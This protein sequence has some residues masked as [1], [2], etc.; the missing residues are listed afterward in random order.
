MKLI[1]IS[2]I[3]RNTGQIEGLPSNP[4]Q[5]SKEKMDKLISNIKQYPEMLSLRGLLVYPHNGKYVIIGG[6][7]RYAALQTLGIKDVPCIVVPNDTPVEKLKAYTIL[8]NNEFGQWDWD[9][10][11]NEWDEAELMDWGLDIEQYCDEQEDT[12]VKEVQVEHKDLPEVKFGEVWQLGCHRLKCGDSLNEKDIEDLM[13]GEVADLLLTDPPYNVNVSNSDGKVIANDNLSDEEFRLFLNK[14]M[15]NASGALKKG[16]AFYVWYGDSES[17]NFRNCCNQN[18]LIVKQCIIWVKS[19]ASLSRQDYNWQHEPCLYGW[20]EGAKHFFVNDY[21][22]TT[23]WEDRPNINQM[24]KEEL[25]NLIKELL[26]SREASTVI[27][28]DKPAHN[29]EHPTMKPIKLMAR[30]IRNSSKKGEIVLDL[31]GGSGSTLIACEQLNRTCYTMEYS[32]EYA[33]VIIKRWETLSGK[34]ATKIK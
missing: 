2:Q 34:K 7:M 9:M 6:N 19:Q 26:E 14:A 31:F 1:D 8:D 18:G 33:S 29:K 21:T 23:I 11:A 13:D 12:N 28:E 10:L 24:N 32:P 5:I 15:K 17:V 25:K 30:Q 22:Q 20:K 4:R 3:E 16:G 27:H